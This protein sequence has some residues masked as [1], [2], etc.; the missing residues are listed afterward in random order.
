MVRFVLCCL[1]IASLAAFV[2]C[3]GGGA[4]N[5]PAVRRNMPTD[6]SA[7]ARVMGQDFVRASLAHPDD[8]SFE[9]GADCQNIGANTYR[10][11][12]KVKAANGFGA[13]LTKKYS[14]TVSYD[15]ESNKWTAVSVSVD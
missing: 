13:K 1:S 5:A 6:R 10:V 4:G 14:A 3:G 15:G 12:G 9:W 7:E 8:A 2:A 11:S